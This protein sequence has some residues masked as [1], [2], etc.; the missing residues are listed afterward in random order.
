MPSPKDRIYTNYQ[1]QLGAFEFNEHVAQ[2]F[3]DMINRSVPGYGMTLDMISVI[4]EA[5]AQPNSICYDLGCSLGGSTFAM[6]QGLLNT[7]TRSSLEP[8]ATFSIIGIDNSPAMVK[9]CTENLRQL[10]KATQ[11]HANH[12]SSATTITT[13]ITTDI[14]CQD[15]MQTQVEQASV[16]TLNFTL[17][18][19]PPSAREQLL[20]HL[21]QGLITGGAL[22]LSEKIIFDNSQTQDMMTNLHHKFKRN[23]GYSDLEIA[24]KRSAIDNVLIPESLDTH[25]ER[26]K[27]AGF[28]HVQ[29]WFQCFNFISLLAIK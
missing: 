27:H 18:F 13:A 22:I 12:P 11:Q 23:E 28:S 19:L 16:I 3:E 7:L 9:R 26:L 15:I 29:P 24:Q 2:V 5:F 21:Y 14:I 17:Q 6:R 10:Q 25:I 4:T 20:Q 1:R 8:D